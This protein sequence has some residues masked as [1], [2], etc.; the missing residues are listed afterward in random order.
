[1]TIISSMKFTESSGPNSLFSVR[2]FLALG[3]VLEFR[4][5]SGLELFFH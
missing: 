3:L 2:I 5:G 1:M 4:L